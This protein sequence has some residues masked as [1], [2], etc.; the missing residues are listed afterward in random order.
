MILG[1]I[2][3]N[4]YKFCQECRDLKLVASDRKGCRYS[5]PVREYKETD[6]TCL[7]CPG[8][9]CKLFLLKISSESNN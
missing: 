4:D 8:V 6:N 1:L 5:C 9:D 2:C 3:T 7:A